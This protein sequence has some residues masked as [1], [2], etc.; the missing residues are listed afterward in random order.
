MQSHV[1]HII[2]PVQ[3]YIVTYVSDHLAASIFT[4]PNGDNIGLLIRCALHTSIQNHTLFIV[5]HSNISSKGQ[6]FFTGQESLF[7]GENFPFLPPYEDHASMRHLDK[8]DTVIKE[9]LK[10]LIL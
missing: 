6:D 7:A 1:F 4:V 9:E 2:C 10:L 8:L 5:F 3:L